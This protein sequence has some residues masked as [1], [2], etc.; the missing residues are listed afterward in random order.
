MY[1]GKKGMI[2]HQEQ[3]FHN[4]NKLWNLNIENVN[5]SCE[6]HEE[7]SGST[8]E[9]IFKPGAMI[10]I[11]DLCSDEDINSVNF[12]LANIMFS[13]SY[14]TNQPAQLETIR[15]TRNIDVCIQHAHTNCINEK[16]I[17]FRTRG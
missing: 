14:D 15:R 6:Q 4:N 1:Y 12:D 16:R 9:N 7:K 11:I 3:F 10:S 17:S 13:D 8:N 2:V 5:K